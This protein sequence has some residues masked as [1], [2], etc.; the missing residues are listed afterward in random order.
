MHRFSI[1]LVF[2]LCVG[3]SQ[4][5]IDTT[6]PTNIAAT[7]AVRKAIGIRQ[8]QSS[9]NFYNREFD[10]EKWSLGNNLAKVVQRSEAEEHAAILW[11]QD[12]Y[13]GSGGLR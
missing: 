9:W 7:N 3:C 10:C 2:V 11:E 6:P 13:F 8:I 12:Y 1:A 5:A 4:S